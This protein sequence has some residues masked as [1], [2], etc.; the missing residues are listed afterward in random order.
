MAATVLVSCYED[1][2]TLDTTKAPLIEIDPDGEYPSVIRVSYMEILD[3][4]PVVRIGDDPY[5]DISCVWTVNDSPDSDD[6]TIISEEKRLNRSLENPATGGYYSLILTVSDHK[7]G[8]IQ[9]KIWDLAITGYP[10]GILVAET[11]DGITSD[12]SLISE[13]AISE[14]YSEELS[15]IRGINELAHGAPLSSLI[16]SVNYGLIGNTWSTYYNLAM[17]ITEDNKTRLYNAI[18]Y[19]NNMTYTFTINMEGVNQPYYKELP[20]LD[21]NLFPN[22]PDNYNPQML[23]TFTDGNNPCIGGV[24][25]NQLYMKG[26]SSAYDFA[27]NSPEYVADGGNY[28]DNGV[29]SISVNPN[30]YSPSTILVWYNSNL[31]KFYTCD[32]YYVGIMPIENSEGFNTSDFPNRQAIAAGMGY[33]GVSHVFLMKNNSTNNYEV[34]QIRQ[35]YYDT[36]WNPMALTTRPVGNVPSSLNNLIETATSIC[37]SLFEPIIYLAKD[38]QITA[39]NYADPQNVTSSVKYTAPE[40]EIITVID[41]FM[42]GRYRYYAGNVSEPLDLTAKALMIATCKGTNEGTLYVVPQLNNGTGNLSSSNIRTYTGFGKI[43]DM[44]VMGE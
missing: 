41:Q 37:F 34:C 33:D 3:I 18:D 2:S 30:I 44:T 27:M 13:P 14:N 25:N 10:T 4:D 43:L 38:N 29:L 1:K 5:P 26:T 17:V 15:V 20:M 24:V 23:F 32:G 42:Q 11:Q 35:S 12:I 19:S 7:T 8:N 21:E 22:K 39:I 6:Y 36:N 16:R 31:G 9:Q 40:G 28:I